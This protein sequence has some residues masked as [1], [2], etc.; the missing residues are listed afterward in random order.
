MN[1]GKSLEELLQRHFGFGAFRQGQREVIDSVLSRRDTVAV[2]PTGS[3]KSLCYQLPALMFRGIT[4]V[5][6]PLIALMKDQVDALTQRGIPATFVN[7]TL[8]LAQETQRLESVRAGRVKLLYVAPERFANARFLDAMSRVFVELFAV[9][10]AHCISQWGHD[11]RPSYMRLALAGRRVGRP[12]ML[13]L[14][15]TA[16]PEVRSDILKN[17]E[18]KDPKVFVTGFDRPNLYL[19]VEAVSSQRDKIKTIKTAIREAGVPGIVYAATR[20]RAEDVTGHLNAAGVQTVCYHAG[21]TDQRRH[22]VQDLFMSGKAQVIAATNA[23]GMGVDK[24]DIR[25]VIHHDLPRSLEAYYQE[26]G[27]AGRDGKPA[28][29]V[30]AYSP[31]D[32]HIQT[33]LIEASNPAPELVRTVYDFL[34]TLGSGE[35]ELSLDEIAKRLPVK[36]SGMAV[37]AALRILAEGGH[38]ERGT[39]RENTAAVRLLRNPALA[40]PFHGPGM[41]CARDV[42]DALVTLGARQGALVRVALE[43]VAEASDLV[44]EKVRVAL[45]GLDEGRTLEYVPPF[46]GRATRL[47]EPRATELQIDTEKMRVRAEREMD[48]LDTMVRFAEAREC[49][50]D[51]IL[52][53]FGETG[54]TPGCGRCDA[55][56]HGRGPA[57]PGS[58]RGAQQEYLTVLE[59]VRSLDGR[60]GRHRIAQVLEGSRE[61][62]VIARG[63]HREAHHAALRHLDHSAIVRMIDRL[64]ADCYLMIDQGEYPLVVV[65]ERGRQAIG[66]GRIEMRRSFARSGAGGRPGSGGGAGLTARARD[67]L[68]YDKELFEALKR[69]RDRIAGQS[70]LRPA[71]LISLRMLRRIARDAPVTLAA[72][73]RGIGLKQESVELAGDAILTVVRRHQE[74]S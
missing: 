2:M 28:R 70:A 64:V 20:K 29:C 57:G 50:R 67:M 35:I 65:T 18:L 10:E 52:D 47:V 33:F 44:V 14:T 8:N 48:R 46:R 5:I 74:S 13:A 40:G 31:S 6:S 71:R 54:H 51:A 42:L 63:L 1:G 62:D 26:V 11:F 27:R 7:S 38:V 37:G 19:S 72:L 45:V 17:L 9:D 15:A 58:G 49:R 34:W 21:L 25:F 3:G 69:C 60:F 39:Q 55:C 68:P 56:Q 61:D 66:S 4:L 16:T 30:L 43:D 32:I 41:T 59:C 24:A 73:R 22:Q 12:T 23:F 53:Y 36:T